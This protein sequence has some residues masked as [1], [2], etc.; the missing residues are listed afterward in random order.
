MPRPD[1]S[2][3]T[4]A[5]IIDAAAEIVSEH[6]YDGLNMRSLAE[7]FGVAPMTLYRHVRTKDDLLAAL[8]DRMLAQLEI[9]PPGDWQ[10]ELEVI[11]SSLHRLLLA[12]PELAEIAIRRPVAGENAYRG[13][14]RVLDALRRGGLVGDAAPS[15][16]SALTV[17]T[18]GFALQQIHTSSRAELGDRLAV[19][20]LLPAEDFPLVKATGTSFLLRDSDRHFEEGLSALLRGLATRSISTQT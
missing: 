11:F 16:F 1:A 14:E 8:A 12:S 19:L 6:G 5:A 3:V 20:E 9:P 10:T 18:Q 13:A 17:Y 15:A 2:H 4:R 7:R